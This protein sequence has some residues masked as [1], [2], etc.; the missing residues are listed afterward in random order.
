MKA[1]LLS[2]ALIILLG[3]SL[4]SQDSAGGEYLIKGKLNFLQGSYE[5]YVYLNYKDFKDSVL[6]TDN[7]FE[8]R[9]SVEKPI[10]A[11]MNLEP[12]ANVAWLYLENSDIEVDANF[13]TSEQNGI[14]WNIMQLIETRGSKS[15][16]ILSTFNS[17]RKENK[18]LLYAADLIEAYISKLIETY[19]NEPVVGKILADIALDG[20]MLKAKQLKELLGK[21]ELDSQQE[22]DIKIIQTALI[23]MEA[24]KMGENFTPFKL[25]DQEGQSFSHEQL[26]GNYVLIDFWASWCKPCRKQNPQLRQLLEKYKA[27]GFDIVGIS[28]DKDATDWRK[29][30][31]EDQTDW[32]QLIDSEEELQEAL[33]I[34]LIPLNYLLD[35][36]GKVMG[37]DLKLDE[38]DRIL[39]K[40]LFP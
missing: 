2:I 33:G 37:I 10:Q 15:E 23:G 6:V 9:G 16:E 12:D 21:M 28:I 11:W 39:A 31:E 25:S 14:V 19:P 35:R 22:S 8:F 3:N 24:V 18:D 4:F 17:F 29:A 5:G 32:K 40:E 7:S 30:I 1:K 13:W 27:E 20:G 38:V 36:D 26:K 34:Q